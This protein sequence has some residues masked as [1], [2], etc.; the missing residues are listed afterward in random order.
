MEKKITAGTGGDRYIPYEKR[1]GNESVVYF[2][3]DLS[4]AGLR[5]IYEKVNAKITGKTAVKLQ[6]QPM[7][8]NK[9]K[10]KVL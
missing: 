9:S 1:T 7:H 2:T 10:T 4:A 8:K 3:R 5:K 6:R